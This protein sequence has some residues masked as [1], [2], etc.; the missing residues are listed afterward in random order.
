MIKRLLE[1]FVP[2]NYK[3]TIDINEEKLSFSGSVRILGSTNKKADQILLHSK[4]LKIIA[5]KVDGKIS[6][7]KIDTQ[8]DELQISS[9]KN[10]N[11][12]H[13]VIDIEFAGKIS[14]DMAGIYSCYFEHNGIKKWIIAT[15]FE[16]HYARQV[17]PCIDEPEA[18][19]TFDLTLITNKIH[20][21]LSNTTP[22]SSNITADSDR[23]ETVFN[24]T[25][26]MSTYL[27]A[28]VTG[29]IHSRQSNTKDGV[30]VTS[31]ASVNQPLENL[32]YSVNEAVKTIEFFNDYFDIPYPLE[33]CDQVAL[34][35]FD[36]GAMENWGLITYRE[37]AMLDDHINPS[38]SSRLYISTVIAHEL[39]HQWFGN[40]VTMKWWDDLWLNESFASLMEYIAVDA[41]HPEW[42]AWE[43]YTSADVISASNRDIYSDVQPVRVDVNDPAEISTLFDGAI[44]Y[45]KGGRLLKMLR[46]YIGDK[47]F[48]DGL[49]RYFLKHS[50]SNT[51]RD[52][53]W[54]TLEDSSNKPVAKIMN[55][56]LEQSG[57]PCLDV[58]QNEN[59]LSIQQKRLVLD[60][61]ENDQIWQI[62][63]LTDQPLKIDVL[64][65]KSISVHLDSKEI[66]LF[67][68]NAS[69]HFVVNYREEKQKDMLINAVK[70]QKLSPS[71]RIDSLN[72]LILLSKAGKE[73][74]V[75]AL[76]LISEC[77]NE[78]RDSVWSLISAIIGHAKVLTEGSQTTESLTNSFIYNLVKGQ[79]ENLGWKPNANDDVNTLQLR[80]T[81]AS[82][83]VASE[84]STVIKDALELYKQTDPASIDAEFRSLL[85]SV[86]VKA[87]NEKD[88]NELIELHRTTASP[89]IRDDICAALTSTKDAA[90][91]KMLLPM[92]KDKEQVRPQDIIRWVAYLQRNKYTRN[93]T[94]EWIK[95]NW[96]WIM[97]TF[98]S[99]KSY[100]YFPRYSA[101]FMNSEYWLKEYKEFYEPMLNDVSLQRTIKIGIKEIGARIAWRERDE[102]KIIEWF[103][104]N[105]SLIR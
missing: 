47:A 79:Y 102:Q 98:A 21:A 87:G 101:N 10:T 32:E 91:V 16:S 68:Q 67:N 11:N 35:D 85:M 103:E 100:D 37:S 29:E 46:E 74:L 56:W 39:S 43:D 33:K 76:D 15:Q 25:P 65:T 104:N 66:V 71:G 73:S 77:G 26:K 95:D 3:L 58:S 55:S 99:S 59:T 45:A 7:F 69:G 64:D 17:F 40:L 94:W 9:H 8:N 30:T 84:N 63:L 42:Q 89:D 81:I 51:T 38:I 61:V 44:V 2:E 96:A 88:I 50:Y 19:A 93:L 48:R 72:N 62:P 53:L 52:D 28:F 27:L 90:V 1:N 92:I 41:I 105:K 36:A 60:S 80:R 75:N 97:D 20:S 12:K 13:C 54:N 34:P 4:D 49:K 14:D 5:V 83:A 24:T 78:P 57:L 6:K 18:K 22:K 70:S 86:A 82:L 23:V 31:W